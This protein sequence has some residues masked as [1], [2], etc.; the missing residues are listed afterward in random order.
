VN[1]ANMPSCIHPEVRLTPD[2]R[3]LCSDCGN[4]L[5]LDHV[6]FSYVA[7]HR[8]RYLWCLRTKLHICAACCSD[9]KME[10]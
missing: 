7:Q 5:W 10:L 9:C 3:I 1:L 4:V 6:V 2:Q 8:P